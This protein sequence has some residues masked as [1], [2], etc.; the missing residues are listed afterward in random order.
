LPS[1]TQGVGHFGV[2]N[3][4]PRVC[5][6]EAGLDGLEHVQVIED[7]IQGAVLGK[8]IEKITDGLFRLH[9]G[10]HLNASNSTP[11]STPR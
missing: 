6:R 2:R 3:N 10:D 1:A 4:P 9:F 7:L 8:T 5:V 11:K